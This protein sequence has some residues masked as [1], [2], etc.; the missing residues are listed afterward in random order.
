MMTLPE[1]GAYAGQVDPPGQT[2]RDCP[3]TSHGRRD[4]PSVFT[5]PLACGACFPLEVCPHPLS[6]AGTQGTR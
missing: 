3:G 1:V 5:R 2:A 6:V 4:A